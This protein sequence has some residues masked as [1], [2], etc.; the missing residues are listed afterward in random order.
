MR[1]P[2]VDRILVIYFAV[3]WSAVVFRI[4]Q[5]PLTWAPMYS[6]YKAKKVISVKQL[7]KEEMKKGLFATHRDGT[8]SYVSWHDLNIP[9][10]NFWRLYQQRMFGG[11]PNT[12]K[13]GNASLGAMNRWV[14]GLARGEDDFTADWTWRI[15]R[16]VN[17]ALGHQPDDPR[18][19]VR[20]EADLARSYF[21]RDDLSRIKVKR[22][23]AILDWREEWKDRESDAGR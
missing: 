17:G 8:T 22:S 20:L 3:L 5:F 6:T 14:R 7:H 18:F 21:D 4:D 9:K 23:H 2:S 11:A 10:W 13:N 15:L 12:F 1:R 19:I 16:S